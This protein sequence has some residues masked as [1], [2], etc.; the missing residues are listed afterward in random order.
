MTTRNK[1]LSDLKE[2]GHKCGW[3]E[4][5]LLY[6]VLNAIDDDSLEDLLEG[7]RA[8]AKN[9]KDAKTPKVQRVSKKSK[10]KKVKQRN[11][12][13]DDFDASSIPGPDED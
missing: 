9:E 3:S 1:I 13:N 11:F 5:T 10:A 6:F 2:I 12:A 7:V 4:S 8:S